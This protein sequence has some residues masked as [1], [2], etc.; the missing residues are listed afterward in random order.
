M[1]LKLEGVLSIGAS[2]VSLKRPGCSSVTI[3]N[4]LGR[5]PTAAG[6][7]IWLDRVIHEGRSESFADGWSGEGP[8]VTVLQQISPALNATAG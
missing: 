7:L 5:E 4:I 1:A 8:V 3:A 6:E 2:Q